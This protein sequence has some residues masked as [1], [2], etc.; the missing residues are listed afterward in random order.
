VSH[1]TEQ[2]LC[3]TFNNCSLCD[4]LNWRKKGLSALSVH[5]K[6]VVEQG[7]FTNSHLTTKRLKHSLN[8]ES[9]ENVRSSNVVEFEFELHH[10]PN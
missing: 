5:M 6:S 8:F 2:K 4:R 1:I 7:F 10:I 9:V 3:S